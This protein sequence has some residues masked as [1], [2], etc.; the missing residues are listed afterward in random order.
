M[1][2]LREA[3]ET[4]EL[5]GNSFLF[6]QT[7]SMSYPSTTQ[8]LFALIVMIIVL[9]FIMVYCCWGTF[10]CASQNNPEDADGAEDSNRNNNNG[11]GSQAVVILPFS[12]MFYVGDSQRRI[13]E[14]GGQDKPPAYSDV[15]GTALGS[16]APMPPPY[17]PTVPSVPITTPMMCAPPPAYQE[18]VGQ[19]EEQPLAPNSE[20][21]PSYEDY[22]SASQGYNDGMTRSPEERSWRGS[23]EDAAGEYN[24]RRTPQ[25]VVVV[26][27]LEEGDEEEEATPVDPPQVPCS[28]HSNPTSACADSTK[29]PVNDPIDPDPQTVT[30]PPPPQPPVEERGPRNNPPGDS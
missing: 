1:R 12:S 23:K 28:H 5:Q 30:G 11:S 27:E 17:T 25:M 15:F 4:M 18:E 9:L 8:A 21:P 22:V 16:R 14:I 10:S 24:S 2:S 3:K 13:Y 6:S 7:A 20:L 26:V 19:V 29:Q